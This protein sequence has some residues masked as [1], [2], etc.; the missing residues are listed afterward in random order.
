MSCPNCGAK[1]ELG[2]QRFCQDC[3]YRLPDLPDKSE[4]TQ[5]YS[6]LQKTRNTHQIEHKLVKTSSSRPLSKASL[7]LGIVSIIIAVTTFNFGTSFFIEPYIL[8][9]SARQL[10]V[11]LFGILNI[12]GAVF[13]IFSIIINVQAKRTES[14]NK[15]MKAGSIL[16]I[17]GTLFNL[18]LMI[19][20]FTIVRIIVV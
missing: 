2:N 4:L 11:I 19:A 5:K 16:G 7:G 14:L 13:G 12:V 1:L 20:A 8:P 3:G 9:S 10:L 18:I 15:A 17:L 6:S